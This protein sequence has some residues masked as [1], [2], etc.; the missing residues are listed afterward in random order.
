M[1]ACKCM[2]CLNLLSELVL[3]EMHRCEV[4]YYLFDSSY[5]AIHP[6]LL[7]N[8]YVSDTSLCLLL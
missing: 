4:F 7:I 5:C 3:D 2:Y 6:T 8:V 1:R